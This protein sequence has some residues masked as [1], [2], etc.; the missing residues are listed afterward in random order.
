MRARVSDDSRVTGFKR[1]I[2]AKRRKVSKIFPCVALNKRDFWE[3]IFEVTS[4][5]RAH[6]IGMLQRGEV[7]IEGLAV[8]LGVFPYQ[9]R[10]E[11]GESCGEENSTS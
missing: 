3:P 4:I 11:F 10:R 7:T 9:I 1:G 5:H 8:A 2:L 6:Y